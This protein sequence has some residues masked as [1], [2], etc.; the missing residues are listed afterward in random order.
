MTKDEIKAEVLR[1]D[2]AFES[3]VNALLAEQSERRVVRGAARR[4]E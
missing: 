2:A 1:G 4:G 3:R